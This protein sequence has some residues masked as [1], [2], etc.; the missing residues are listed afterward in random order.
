VTGRSAR[1]ARWLLSA[2]VLSAVCLHDGAAL[3]ALRTRQAAAPFQFSLLD[4]EVRQIAGQLGE[5]YSALIGARP[6]ASESDLSA[7]RRY[8]LEPVASRLEQRPRAEL[9]IQRLVT[10][11]W[12]AD[13]L[14]TQTLLAVGGTTLFPPVSFTF[15][16]PP[17]VLIVSPRDRIEVREHVLVRPMLGSGDVA[18]LER[19]VTD[20]GLSSLVTP[21]GGLSTYP[22]MVLETGSAASILGAVAH[23]WA[24]AFFY[25]QPLGR[26]YWSDQGLRTINE[27]AA[28]LAGVELGDRLARQ[29]GLPPNPPRTA[30]GPRQ[31]E[32]ERLL[33]TTRLEIDRLLASGQIETAERYMEQRRLEINH[34]GYE[35]RRL[36]QAYFAFHGSYAEGPAGSSPLAGRVRRLRDRSP[37]LGSFL[38]SVAQVS[39]P[40]DLP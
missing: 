26:G 24:H 13:G 4:W 6:A 23:E 12:I 3:E 15:T 34:L 30:P 28:E 17:Q 37:S 14:Q 35:L 21:I 11:A 16:S 29:L 9:A 36:N 38:R 22:A 32:F 40:R 20:R 5:I 10:D 7:L 2:I 39:N 31:A 8:F 25:F 33:R 27:T 19:A 18:N 1:A